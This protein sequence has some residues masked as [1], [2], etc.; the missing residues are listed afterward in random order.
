MNETTTLSEIGRRLRDAAHGAGLTLRELGD[1]MGVS[2]PTIYAYASGALK[3][4][5]SRLEQAAQI[6]GNPVSYFDPQSVEDLDPRSSTIQSFKLIDAL[7]SPPSPAKASSAALE[8]LELSPEAETP[9]IRAELL[10]RSGNALTL[11]GDYVTAVRH[12]ESAKEIF[13]AEKN[14]GKQ[15]MCLQTLGFCYINLGQIDRA[16]DSFLDAKS[17]LSPSSQWKADVALAALAERIGD[18]EDAESQLSRMLD[19]PVLDD[20]ALTYVRANY[21][22]I[23]CTRGRWKSGLAQTDT[24]L[25][26]AL[27]NNLPDQVAEMLIQAAFALTFLGRLEEA[28]MMV[29]RARDVAFTL[30]DEARSTLAEVALAYLLSAFGD[31]TAART[32]ASHAYS[33]AMRGQYRRSESQAL[34]LQAE[35]AYRRQDDLAAYELAAQVESHGVAN[36]YVVAAAI[37]AGIQAKALARLGRGSEAQDAISAAQ[38]AVD[39]IGEGRSHV[40]LTE[41]KAVVALGSNRISEAVEL[42]EIAENE[43]QQ[44]ELV[45]DAVRI[46]EELRQYCELSGDSGGVVDCERRIAALE[47][48]TAG[49]CPHPEVWKR[50][51]V[52]WP[53]DQRPQ[54]GGLRR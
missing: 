47:E 4:S 24:A 26:A 46:L 34:I 18:F 50:F 44:L 14:L 53:S 12:L 54:A 15:G 13:V 29:V 5:A 2:R 33:R 40:L 19:D 36:Q 23:V 49:M 28:T 42:F 32:S 35:L 3:M 43:A 45:P 8:A 52:G 21:S 9:G 41:A 17:T 51:L 37:G 6:T 38:I 39:R 20:E 22:N 31:E 25:N 16:R 11:T 48:E 30:K 27:E 10:R 7:M 1:K